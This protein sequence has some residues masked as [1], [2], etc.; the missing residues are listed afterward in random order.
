MTSHKTKTGIDIIDLIFQDPDVEKINKECLQNIINI[1]FD[2]NIL[3][4]S[5]SEI[6]NLIYKIAGEI[7]IRKRRLK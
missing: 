3:E 2:K 6:G 5:N 7:E 4:L 1:L